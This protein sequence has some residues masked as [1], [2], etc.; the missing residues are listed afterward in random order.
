MKSLKYIVATLVLA[1]GFAAPAMNAQDAAPKS[2]Q[3]RPDMTA[4][5]LKGIT[6]TADQQAKVDAI[7]ADTQKQ[8]QGL[9]QEDRRAK[10]REIAQSSQKKIRAVL[11]EDQQ[12][13]FD[14][15]VK[16]A[17]QRNPGAGKNKGSGKGKDGKGPGK[18]SKASEE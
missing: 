2:R 15:N 4:I 12:A 14:E 1:L 5:W 10:G 7:K 16:A 13:K 3:N 9:A 18:A 6:L 17:Q 11:T 8:I